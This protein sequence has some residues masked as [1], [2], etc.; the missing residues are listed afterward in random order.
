MTTIFYI[1]LHYKKILRMWKA[2]AAGAGGR[3]EGKKKRKMNII[4]Y[5][6]ILYII[7]Y[8]YVLANIVP[9]FANTRG[10]FA[11]RFFFFDC[12]CWGGF[13][14]PPP[15]SHP[16]ALS[17]I[18]LRFANPQCL[19]NKINNLTKFSL[20]RS[21]ATLQHPKNSQKTLTKSIT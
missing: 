8:I 13:R 4:L 3:E 7:L 16:P 19:P 9:L 10:V 17:Q 11:K 15:P 1:Y 12:Q 2:Y 5:Y 20:C 14:F 21:C 6:I 18:F